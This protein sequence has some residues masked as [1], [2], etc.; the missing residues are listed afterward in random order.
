MDSLDYKKWVETAVRPES[1][2]R[3]Q[4][5]FASVARRYDLANTMMSF[6][7]HYPWKRFTVKEAALKAGDRVLDCCAGTCDLAILEAREAG[8]EGRVVA[9]DF[10]QEMLDVGKFKVEKA[11]LGE[12]VSY[13][14]GNA[15]E[16][17]FEPES[18]NA[19]TIGV[20]SR[21]LDVKKAYENWFRLLK[22]GGRVVCLDFFTPPNPGFR[23]L[24]GF[25]ADRVLP[26]IGTV[27]TR[28]RT[29]VYYYLHKSVKLFFTPDQYA[30]I[31]ASAG[32]EN[33][34]YTRLTGGIVC[35][36]VGEKPLA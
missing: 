29:G 35:V 31:I 13:C 24:Y 7:M 27:V 26:R 34:R 23:A 28:D 6:G 22:P 18:F 12:R 4:G 3:V 17:P 30:E 2:E 19:V 11:G 10:N 9:L 25:Y 14:V 20:A 8:P 32:F 15:E 21:H 16:P 33:V 5:M 1:E 36:H